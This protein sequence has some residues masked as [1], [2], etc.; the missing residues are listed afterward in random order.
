MSQKHRS[1]SLEEVEA[2]LEGLGLT[3]RSAAAIVRLANTL[4]QTRKLRADHIHMLGPGKRRHPPSPLAGQ[5]WNQSE[6]ENIAR[7]SH[8]ETSISNTTSVGP[9][10]PMLL[11]EPTQPFLHS[12]FGWLVP[13][14]SP[15]KD[16]AA[17]GDGLVSDVDLAALT[18][19]ASRVGDVSIPED[20][21]SPQKAPSPALI[22]VED[23]EDAA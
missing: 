18:D 8:S 4:K 11:P 13:L 16:V 3:R 23:G 7:P 21:S 9:A 10:K 20:D 22:A 12:D 15:G 1:K 5:V 17:L 6:V 14:I 2:E 19:A